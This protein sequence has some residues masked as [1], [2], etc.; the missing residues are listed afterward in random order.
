MTDLTNNYK[1]DNSGEM[2][3]EA[4]EMK[5]NDNTNIIQSVVIL[6]IIA[7]AVLAGMS[8]LTQPTVVPDSAPAEE[9]SAERAMEH[10]RAILPSCK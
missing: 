1:P 3:K 4:Q 8:S 2:S 6:L 5:K 7:V 9:F 10:I